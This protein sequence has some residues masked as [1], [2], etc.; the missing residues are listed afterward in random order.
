VEN[1]V[2]PN[3]AALIELFVASGIPKKTGTENYDYWTTMQNAVY[4]KQQ[5]KERE[6]KA[7]E[8]ARLQASKSSKTFPVA[9]NASKTAAKT[10]SE[11]KK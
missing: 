7:A 3:A 4:M 11:A 9:T 5:A 1:I 8:K 10:A 2:A 6:Q